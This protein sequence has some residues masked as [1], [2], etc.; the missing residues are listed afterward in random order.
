V[1]LRKLVGSR[2]AHVPSA[3]WD[4]AHVGAA[5][6]TPAH[7]VRALEA[8]ASTVLGVE[9]QA[10][11]S[12]RT[13]IW[14]ALTTATDIRRVWVPGYTCVAVPNAVA[15]AGFEIRW[16]DVDGPN[17]DMGV[18][19][20]EGRP[21]DAV[22][23]QHTYGVP[24]DPDAIDAAR[25]QGLYVIEDRAHR[26]DAA[27]A[28]G[29]AV[30]FSLEH[31]KV[32]SGGQGGLLHVAGADQA[33]AIVRLIGTLPQDAA[34][35]V[36]RIVLTSMGQLL[37]DWHAPV[38]DRAGAAIRRALLRLPALSAEGQTAD[39]LAGEGIVPRSLHPR[40]AR[41]AERAIRR[42]DANLA[43]R[44]RI[45]AIYRERLPALTPSWL[46]HDTPLVRYPL[47]VG[48]GD[49]VWRRV[50]RAGIDLGP[51]WFAAPV[52][53]AGSRSSYVDGLAPRA[54]AL[55]RAVLTLPTHLR[56][57]EGEAAR[58]ADA[59]TAATRRAA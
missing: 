7:A 55:S 9:C 41:L 53:P 5:V 56:V 15:A 23:A 4:L 44:R 47:Q 51:R 49:D 57:S 11:G 31:S 32:V 50:R 59:V 39:E 20:S 17:L 12:A 6:S 38:A 29:D 52:H 36:R 30:V 37:F 25:Q 43:H 16:V 27:E 35:G 21:G 40:L 19:L 26:F 45:A 1:T 24:V 34:A 48:D 33:A 13:A 22:L 10:V 3:D 28:A 54:E 46:P 14:A 18:V 58:I 42:V 8:A 2:L